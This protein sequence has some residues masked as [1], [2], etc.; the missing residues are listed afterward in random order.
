MVIQ[1]QRETLGPS[2]ENIGSILGKA[3]QQRG[4]L[5]QKQQLATQKAALASK[6]AMSKRVAATDKDLRTQANFLN[7][8]IQT[9]EDYNKL[10]A[11]ALQLQEQFGLEPSQASGAALQEWT[12]KVPYQPQGQQVLGQQPGTSPMGQAI[13]GATQQRIEQPS[14][15]DFFKKGAESSISGRI[16]SIARG[17]GDEAF[18]KGTETEG[19]NFLQRLVQSTGKFGGDLPYY[20]AGGTVGGIAGAPVGGPIGATVGGAAGTIALPRMIETA[21]SEYQKYVDKGGEGSFEDFILSAG[22][23]GQAGIEGG[24]EGV[25]FGTLG[26]LI[27]PLKKFPQ[28]KKLFESKGGAL[29]EKATKGAIEAGGLVGAKAV[30]ERKIPTSEEVADTFAQVIGL[31][32]VNMSPRT[33]KAIEKKVIDSKIEPTTFAQK[34]A[35]QAQATG[36]SLTKEADV[37]SLVNRVSKEKPSLETERTTRVAK[38]AEPGKPAEETRVREEQVT[39]AKGTPRVREEIA[40]EKERVQE[41]ERPKVRRAE[42]VEREVQTKKQASQELPK[43]ETDLREINKAYN[44]ARDELSLAKKSEVSQQEI[45]NAQKEHDRLKSLRDETVERV[46]GLKSELK[47]GE[48]YISEKD[49]QKK[50][51]EDA[52]NEL[53]KAKTQSA[54]EIKGNILDE[55][56]EKIK[57]RR[58]VPG[59]EKIPED[60][61]ARV[62]RIYLDQFQRKLGEVRDDLRFADLNTERGKQLKNAEARLEKQIEQLKGR[63]EVGRRRR[64]LHEMG[65]NVEAAQKFPSR[66]SEK[67]A[68]KRLDASK[69]FERFNVKE[70][71]IAEETAK[72]E[73]EASR[74]SDDVKR[75]RSEKKTFQASPRNLLSSLIKKSYERIFNKPLSTGAALYVG[76]IIAKSLGIQ[77]WLTPSGLVDRVQDTWRALSMLPKDSRERTLYLRDLQ[78]DGLSAA[79]VKRIRDYAKFW[80]KTQNLEKLH[81]S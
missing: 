41:R 28:L 66:V 33:R 68:G 79:R 70:E 57:G 60:T 2:L 54:S 34:I 63:Y 37:L 23:V 52:E 30:A 27:E 8:S 50:A 18:R 48:K 61:F 53:E 46:K 69:V 36:K 9:E 39:Y 20:A 26:K 58:T 22:K 16:A 74:I 19:A 76:S 25:I 77:G 12:S 51:Y 7:L 42:T 15:I 35:E 80:E 73:K 59:Q 62:Q 1:L 24:A 81:S 47:T 13:Q 78:K 3:L 14:L 56:A 49:L 45:N 55:L 10:I 67:G 31:N 64:G 38:E 75:A 5:L 4:E 43:A 65:R 32:L 17:E 72:V 40:E 71:K 29:L 44:V 21:L 6:E 11:R